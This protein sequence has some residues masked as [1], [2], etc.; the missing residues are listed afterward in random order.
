MKKY[1][2]CILF[3]ATAIASLSVGNAQEGLTTFTEPFISLKYNATK[4]YTAQLQFGNRNY[5]YHD[6]E[7]A[8]R[9]QL[10]DLTHISALKIG[11]ASKLGMGSS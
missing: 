4:N 3:L 11:T 1:W 2:H 8:Y 5:L 7:Y 9:V 10:L 6:S